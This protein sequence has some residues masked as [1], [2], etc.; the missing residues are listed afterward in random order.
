MHALESTQQLVADRP[1]VP[2]L[3]EAVACDFLAC[4]E[5]AVMIAAMGDG[6]RLAGADLLAIVDTCHD[7]IEEKVADLKR[8]N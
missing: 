5:V 2:T 6:I 4:L 3:E 8:R 7:L 1:V